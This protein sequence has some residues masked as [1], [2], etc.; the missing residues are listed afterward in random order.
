MSPEPSLP[1]ADH[2]MTE[3]DD[4][5]AIWPPYEAFYIQAMLFNAR[6]ALASIGEAERILKA[7]SNGESIESGPDTDSDALLNSL[8][9]VVIHGAALSRYFWPAR[10][11]HERRAEFLKDTLQI[12]EESPL[13]SRDLRNQIEHFDEKLDDYVSSGIVGNVFPAY[14]GRLPVEDVP[15]HMFRAYYADVG[16]FE[17]LGKRYEM[18]PLANEIAR[19]HDLLESFDANGGRLKSSENKDKRAL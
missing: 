11:G 8:Q 13:K 3:T 16:I 18:S 9:N 10:T 4:K 15:S 19:I 2:T 6:A 5:F 1:M 17:M 12:T 7:M 14:V